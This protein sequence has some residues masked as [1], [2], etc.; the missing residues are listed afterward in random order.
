M[1]SPFA[2]M[3][4]FDPSP[5]EKEGMLISKYYFIQRKGPDGEWITRWGPFSS[6]HE[7]SK[8]LAR[9][10]GILRITCREE[11]IVSDVFVQEAD[12]PWN[13]YSTGIAGIP[14][15]LYRSDLT[16]VIEVKYSWGDTEV[17]KICDV[18]WSSVSCWRRRD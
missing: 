18:V 8:C 15:D 3:S 11:I 2:G 4:D 7:A 13:V 5:H 9:Y 17:L 16:D 1:G 10:E 12:Q 6:F 14:P